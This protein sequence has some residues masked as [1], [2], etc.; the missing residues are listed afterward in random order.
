VDGQKLL[1]PAEPSESDLNAIRN[2]PVKLADIR[3]RLSDISWWMRLLVLTGGYHPR[4]YTQ[5]N[6]SSILILVRNFANRR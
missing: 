5:V 2:D 1:I 4:C 6:E 3:E